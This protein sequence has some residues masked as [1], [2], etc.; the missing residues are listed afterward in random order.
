MSASNRTDSH[1][2]QG[3]YTG[4]P[5]DPLPCREIAHSNMQTAKQATSTTVNTAH[6]LSRGKDPAGTPARGGA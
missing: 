1:P 4:T 5:D 3:V 2:S 6:P